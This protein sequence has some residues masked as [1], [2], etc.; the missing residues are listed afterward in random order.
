M[1][2]VD[3][4]TRKWVEDE[5]LRL[6]L[7]ATPEATEHVYAVVRRH[8]EACHNLGINSDAC[9]DRLIKEAYEDYL[10]YVRRGDS[11]L[12]WEMPPDISAFWK[13]RVYET[14]ADVSV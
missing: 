7:D 13:Y 9:E 14:P 1:I 5:M 11:I 3:T 2:T 12:Y 8:V 6:R 4:A 10:D